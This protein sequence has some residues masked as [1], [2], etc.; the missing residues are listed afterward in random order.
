MYYL[1]YLDDCSCLSKTDPCCFWRDRRNVPNWH[2]RFACFEREKQ[3]TNT[4]VMLLH[5]EGGNPIIET[6]NEGGIHSDVFYHGS[7]AG[8]KEF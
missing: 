4:T 2:F 6:I 5:F 3:G 1:F 8:K 7:Y